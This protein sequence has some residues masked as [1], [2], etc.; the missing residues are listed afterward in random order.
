M[1]HLGVRVHQS[2]SRSRWRSGCRFGVI[3]IPGGF[4]PLFYKF[5]VHKKSS[6]PNEFGRLR[7][8]RR[9]I[10][11]FLVIRNARETFQDR[12]EN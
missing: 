12:F 8:R 1:T 2:C 9:E 7:L 6:L 3:S 5:S 4:S 10:R 11:Q